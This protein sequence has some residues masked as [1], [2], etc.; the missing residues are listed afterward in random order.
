MR[1]PE[2]GRR[3]ISTVRLRRG[4][5]DDASAIAGVHVSARRHSLPYIPELHSENETRRW[6]VDI[7][8]PNHDVWVATVG[9]VVVGY[10]ALEG[11]VLHDLYVLP[12]VHGR[13][14]GS[15][16]LAKA[17]ELSPGRLTLWTFQQN[18]TA[19][20]FYERRGFRAVELTDGAGNEEREPD[21][22]Y[23]WT[24]SADS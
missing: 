11:P 6:V 13:G 18:A 17:K 10:I 5:P 7:V 3:V 20:A 15:S 22:R 8:L 14:I 9:G 12:E 23:E 19:R 1:G 16:L 4:V 21:V 2:P 24:G